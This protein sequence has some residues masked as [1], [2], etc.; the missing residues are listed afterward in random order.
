MVGIGFNLN[1]DSAG[2]TN[3]TV[4]APANIVVTTVLS[5]SG[6]GNAVAR[7][8]ITDTGSATSW[9]VDA[10]K[11]TSGVAIPI[12]SFNTACWDN[13]GTYLTAGA[14]IQAVHITIP[15]DATAD[16]PFAICLAGVTFQ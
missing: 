3:G 9:C 2:A 12:T 13:S 15:S 11:W 10:G 4:S 8:Q 16:R 6:A 5:G 14:A 7:V 1:Q